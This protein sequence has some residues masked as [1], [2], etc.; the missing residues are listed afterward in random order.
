MLDKIKKF[1]NYIIIKHL[2]KKININLYTNINLI[3]V[4]LYSK[5]FKIRKF[6]NILFQKLQFANKI[7]Q[8]ILFIYNWF[9][10]KK[11]SFLYWCTFKNNFFWHIFKIKKKSLYT[12]RGWIV[13]NKPYFKKRKVKT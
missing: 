3:R 4:K 7:I 6:K 5:F 11:K 8:L 2:S 1:K 10:K 12:G 9:S 13:K